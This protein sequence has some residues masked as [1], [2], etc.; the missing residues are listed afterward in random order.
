[1]MCFM[2]L[3]LAYVGLKKWEC[4]EG[5]TFLLPFGQIKQQRVLW[6]YLQHYCSNSHRMKLQ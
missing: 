1:M 4:Q 5:A 2:G 6:P 3:L